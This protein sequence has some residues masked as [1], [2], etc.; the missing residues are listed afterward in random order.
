MTITKSMELFSTH[1]MA[2]A[3][4]ISLFFF[5]DSIDKS[6][7]SKVLFRFKKTPKL[8]KLIDDYWQGKLRVD[9]QS[10]FNQIKILKT[11]I[12]AES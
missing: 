2:L 4:A 1:D 8:N 11:R 6:N 9:P 10:Y 3:S 5:L 7:P 12:Y